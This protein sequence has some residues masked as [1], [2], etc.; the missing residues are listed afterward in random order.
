MNH[1]LKILSMILALILCFPA[2]QAAAHIAYRDIFETADSQI[3]NPDGSV[4]YDS[5]YVNKG[6][7][8]SWAM[9]AQPEWMD[10][11]TIP[12]YKFDIT[13]ADGA[14][15]N[16]SVS[17][18]VTKPFGEG[19]DTYLGDL[20]PAFTLYK[21]LLP[22]AAHDGA[23][24]I[25][26]KLG[27]WNAL[28]DTTMGNGPGPIYDIDPVT[29][30]TILVSNDPGTVATIHYLTHAGSVGST[31][32]SVSINNYFLEAGSYTIALGGTCL[33]CY[34]RIEKLDPTSPLYDPNFTEEEF[35]ALENNGQLQRGFNLNLT[36]QPVPVP[37]AI[38]LMSSGLLA[39][40][41]L[42]KRK[43]T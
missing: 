6:N 37:T 35:F 18:G 33:E 26:G 29:G 23:T 38:W 3:T 39:F 12:W 1:K 13:N 8:Y 2:Q 43:T 21:G 40:L 15:I 10:S 16:L 30:E 24:L 19:T 28:G 27:M 36:V 11:H 31:A 42:A 14:I 5:N 20:T 7:N 17:G 32:T 4:T 34:A 25:E 9:A 41:D 22:G